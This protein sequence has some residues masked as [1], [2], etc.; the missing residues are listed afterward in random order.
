MGTRG[1]IWIPYLSKFHFRFEIESDPDRSKTSAAVAISI[2]SLVVA[3]MGFVFNV[4]QGFASQR[5]Y[6]DIGM[7]QDEKAV[8]VNIENDGTGPAFLKKIEISFRHKPLKKFEDL[9]QRI[10]I[11]HFHATVSFYDFD[12]TNAFLK[13][14]GSAPVVKM[15]PFN[16][17][18]GRSAWNLIKD[19]LQIRV[20]YC[21]YY[22]ECWRAC[23]HESGKACDAFKM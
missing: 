5:P 2:F 3:G 14:D 19:Q 18:D 13:K 1:K 9:Y 4:F 22:D 15:R 17:S 6:L 16:N 10:L 11:E 23:L 20:E 12:D 7:Y 21:S 8:G